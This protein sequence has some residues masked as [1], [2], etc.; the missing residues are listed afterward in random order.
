MPRTLLKDLVEDR[1]LREVR[2]FNRAYDRVA[3]SVDPD[4]VGTGPSRKQLDRWLN[5]RLVSK[6]H[7]HHCRVLERMFPGHP[8]TELFG[9][10]RP[11]RAT[12]VEPAPT[13]RGRD[14]EAATNR[15]DAFRAGG[16]AMAGLVMH[17]VISE[18]DQ[19]HAALDTGSVGEG[20]LAYLE[21]TTDDLGWRI[22]KEPAQ[23][24][25]EESLTTFASVRTLIREPQRTADRVRLVRT[26][27]RLASIVGEILFDDRQ[28]NLA[29]HWFVIGQRAALDIG[30]RPLADICLAKQSNV[31][32]Y[33]GDPRGV[34]ALVDPRL[35]GTPP[36][37]SP[38]VAALWAAKARAHATL[39]ENIAFRHAANRSRQALDAAPPEPETPTN[40][41]FYPRRLAFYE[42]TGLV[43][44]G[45]SK[46]ALDAADRALDQ[47]EPGIYSSEPAMIRLNKA[48]VHA[49]S[50]EIPEACRIATEALTDRDSHPAAIV[51]VRAAEFDR[52]LG[53]DA[54]APVR[55]WRDVLHRFTTP[56]PPGSQPNSRVLT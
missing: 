4:L 40:F 34:L 2:A 43:Q 15:R 22:M 32:A 51:L 41:T 49:R 33:S 23:A 18:P 48:V 27:G 42:V 20:R 1:H 21:H 30:D 11:D 7:P 19:M 5:G 17:Q 44:L 13:G 10:P 14:E 9:P 26:G 24:L 54:S 50:G 16:A 36:A 47:Y 3:A 56:A 28:F 8:V 39:G 55:E 37:A 29:R 35:D 45:D 53:A 46:A 6:P 38:G 52:M 31:P 25:L 12:P